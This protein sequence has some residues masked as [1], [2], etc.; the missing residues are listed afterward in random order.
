MNVIVFD[1]ET[2]G[3]QTQSLLNVGYTIVDLDLQTANINKVYVSRDYLIRNHFENEMLMLNDMFVGAEK[4]EL[5][6][7]N[8]ANKGAI[9]R[10]IPQIFKTLSNDIAKYK[11][12]FGYAYNS[13]FDEDKF[14]KT[15]I[16]FGLPNP[17]ATIPIHDLWGYAY[18]YI[19]TTAE[20]VAYMKAHELFTDTKRF[21]KTSVEGVTAYLND[22]P[23]FT[24]EHTALSDVQWEL[25][26]LQEV[27]RRGCDITKPKKRG[28][29]IPSGVVFHKTLVIDGQ[30]VE[31][32]YTKM[33]RKWDTADK[34]TFINESANGGNNSPP[35]P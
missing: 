13:E 9:L 10:T 7:Q 33:S 24:E 19:C 27:L 12:L 20:Y 18:H 29:M 14:E 5:M 35:T 3:V 28:K 32:D 23:N 21:I 2:V 22:D 4:W 1:T 17:I 31:V 25:K 6:K 16:Q 30:E 34:I 15:A 26:I 8:V 11:P